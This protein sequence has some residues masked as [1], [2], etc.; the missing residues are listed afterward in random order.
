MI[1]VKEALGT[2]D[3]IFLPFAV[4]DAILPYLWMALLMAGSAWHLKLDAIN[5]V[6]PDTLQDLKKRVLKTEHQEKPQI[7]FL[8]FLA[9]LS[10]GLTVTFV[11]R[12]ASGFLP[13][14]KDVISP[15][16]WVIILAS[17]A[18]LALSYTPIRK[19]E[20]SGSNLIGYF[21]LY[22]VLTTIGAKANLSQIGESLILMLAGLIVIV[23]HATALLLTCRI[24]KAPSCLAAIASQANLGGVASA[25]IVAEI[26]H[27]GLAPVGLLLA[28]FGNI[29]GTYIGITVGQL[30]RMIAG[31]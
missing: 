11:V 29:I 15:F 23:I 1:A 7:T 28:I 9:M 30:C 12:Q 31:G 4:V 24:F 26:Y 8:T 21:F 19:L 6:N 3:E 25:P 22:L 27:K 18:G 13:S 14:I 10:I 20:H 17:A 16:T 2:P 5:G